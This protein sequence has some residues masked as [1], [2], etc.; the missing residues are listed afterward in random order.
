MD[1]RFDLQLVSGELLD[2][3]GLDY[4]A[5][6]YQ[7]FGNNGTHMLGAA[8]GAD[9]AVL[10]ALMLA[11]DHLPVV[12]NSE[13]TVGVLLLIHSLELLRRRLP[14]LARHEVLNQLLPCSIPALTGPGSGVIL[15][16]TGSRPE[17][18]PLGF[19]GSAKRTDR[20]LQDRDIP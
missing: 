5:G 20:R 9:P 7:V 3:I 6:S 4:V 10:E 15:S 2:G 19:N 8:I 11:S 13:P 18:G 12:A 14:G 17:S 1:D 16:T